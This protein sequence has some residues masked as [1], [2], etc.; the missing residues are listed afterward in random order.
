MYKPMKDS[1]INEALGLLSRIHSLIRKNT[2]RND[3]EVD[4][5]GNGSSNNNDNKGKACQKKKLY[6]RVFRDLSLDLAVFSTSC[7]KTK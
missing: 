6:K 5:D 3:D 1:K 4:D 7:T 2:T